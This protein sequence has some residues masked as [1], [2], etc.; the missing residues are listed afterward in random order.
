MEAEA[1]FFQNKRLSRSLSVSVSVSESADFA[2]SCPTKGVEIRV[3]IHTLI[4]DSLGPTISILILWVVVQTRSSHILQ[5][6]KLLLV[7]FSEEICLY[8]ERVRNQYVFC[9]THRPRK[10]TPCV[11][12]YAT[13]TRWE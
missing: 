2:L 7:L 1:E 6:Q 3:L 10:V 9:E 12:I 8:F 11:Y 13:R 5:I 4:S